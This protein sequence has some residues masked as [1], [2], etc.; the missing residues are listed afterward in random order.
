M[1]RGKLVAGETVLVHGGAGGTGFAA[2]Q[3]AKALGA[4][5]ISTAGGPDKAV[6]CKDLGADCRARPYGRRL[7]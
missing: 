2:I 4:K 3:L 5:V 6:V 1:R 7:G